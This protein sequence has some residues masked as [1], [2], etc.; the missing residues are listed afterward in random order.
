MSMMRAL[1]DAVPTSEAG[2]FGTA[3]EMAVSCRIA[4]ASPSRPARVSRVASAIFAFMLLFLCKKWRQEGAASGSRK[5]QR[6]G[7]GGKGA[8]TERGRLGLASQ[9]G[10]RGGLRAREWTQLSVAPARGRHH[11]RC[12]QDRAL[13]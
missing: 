13:E 5:V 1:A 4:M 10:W 8:A 12:S 3:S 2:L 6:L 11:R 7:L 9:R